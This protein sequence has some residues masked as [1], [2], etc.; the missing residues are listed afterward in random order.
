MIDRSLLS[1]EEPFRR[2]IHKLIAKGTEDGI[3]FKVLE[4]MRTPERQRELFKDGKSQTLNSKHLNGHAVDLVPII[5]YEYP[6]AKILIW[7]PHHKVW[8]SVRKLAQVYEVAWGGN[9]VGFPDYFHF[10]DK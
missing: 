9:W 10:Q 3:Y 5:S 7:S 4:T 1:L 8:D 2:K 6:K